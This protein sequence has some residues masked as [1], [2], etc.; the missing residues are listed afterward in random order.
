MS[1]LTS[2]EYFKDPDQSSTKEGNV[3]ELYNN[4]IELRSEAPVRLFSGRANNESAGTRVEHATTAFRYNP[5]NR[6]SVPSNYQD[7]PTSI[8]EALRDF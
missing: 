6:E 5:D 7:L 2:K 4:D 3:F 8:Q 1:V